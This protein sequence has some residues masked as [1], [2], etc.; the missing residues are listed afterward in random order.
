MEITDF[1][2]EHHIREPLRQ[3]RTSDKPYFIE[4]KRSNFRYN[5]DRYKERSQ[6]KKIDITRYQQWQDQSWKRPRDVTTQTYKR[7]N[8]YIRRNSIQGRWF[9]KIYHERR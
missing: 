3:N 2:F 6:T 1:D 5:K 8:Q 4:R 9:L 7:R